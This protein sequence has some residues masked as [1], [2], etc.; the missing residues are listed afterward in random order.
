M[1][2][3]H[4]GCPVRIF[5][6]PLGGNEVA[7]EWGHSGPKDT[8]DRDTMSLV[9]RPG[10]RWSRNSLKG[11]VGKGRVSPQEEPWE[12]GVSPQEGPQGRGECCPQGGAVRM[13]QACAQV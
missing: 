12:R 1:G 13:T 5:S 6:V 9:N 2:P 11:A 8:G 4:S 10:P 7:P 3:A